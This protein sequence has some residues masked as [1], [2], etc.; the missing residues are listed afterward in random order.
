[1]AS[2]YLLSSQ[3]DSTGDPCKN[4]V[5]DVVVNEVLDLI[6]EDSSEDEEKTSALY[7]VPKKRAMHQFGPATS[8]KS[9]PYTQYIVKDEN[10]INRTSTVITYRTQ[11]QV[12]VQFSG[13]DFGYPTKSLV[14]SEGL[15]Q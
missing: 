6:P 12:L 3:E 1:M 9:F 13:I 7:D 11:F 8:K 15:F 14:A 5:Y 4:I 2:F 10:C